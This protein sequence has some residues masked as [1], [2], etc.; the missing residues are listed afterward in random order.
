MCF[1]GF[2]FVVW[3]RDFGYEI[4]DVLPVAW[5]ACSGY[6]LLSFG[7][8]YGCLG[9]FKGVEFATLVSCCSMTF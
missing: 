2:V 6:F 9:L 5:S 8:S 3:L 7:V 4:V 1:V